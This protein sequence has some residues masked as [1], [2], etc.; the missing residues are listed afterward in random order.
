MQEDFPEHRDA[1]SSHG[2]SLPSYRFQILDSPSQPH[3]YISQFLAAD[4]SA[5]LVQVL[6]F[7]ISPS[8]RFTAQMMSSLQ[9]QCPSEQGDIPPL[10]SVLLTAGLMQSRL[11]ISQLSGTLVRKF[12]SLPGG[13]QPSKPSSWFMHSVFTY[14]IPPLETPSQEEVIK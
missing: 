1:E 4:L 6:V 2:P 5:Y 14:A 13:T 8:D 10:G 12:L 9:P 3:N 11:T 7:N